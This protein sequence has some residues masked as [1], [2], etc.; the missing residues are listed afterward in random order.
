M[1]QNVD[2]IE[3]QHSEFDVFQAKLNEQLDQLKSI[4][5]RPGFGQDTLQLG[6]ELEMYLVDNT[7]E[8]SL[9]NQQLLSL[10]ND[11]QYQ[12]EL[13]QYNLE[14]N[15]SPVL[16]AGTPF[17]N[18]RQQMQ[19]KTARLEQVAQSININIVPIGILPTLR[20]AHMN[21]DYM[22]DIQRYHCLSKHLYQERGGHFEININGDESLLTSFSDICAEG[23]NTSFQVH[24]MIRPDKFTQVYNAA[25]LTLPFVTAIGANSGI[26]LGRK[27]WDE[28]RIA[29]FKQSI[30]IRHPNDKPWQEQ[31]RVNFGTG[32]LHG[33]PFQLFSQAVSLFPPVIPAL[34]D[35]P[36][37]KALPPLSELSLHLGTTWPWHRPVYSNN[38]NGHIRLE[39]RAIPA[40]PTSID[41]LANAAFAIGLAVGFSELIDDYISVLPFQYAEYNFYRAAQRGLNAKVLWPYKHKYHVGEVSIAAIIEGI[42][43]IAKQGLLSLDITEQ[44]TDK[45]LRVIENRL[46]DKI[47]GA[48]WQKRTFS[49]L[50]QSQTRELACKTLTQVYLQNCRTCRPVSEWAQLWR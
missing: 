45:Y 9:S 31:P 8:V 4:M 1:G 32:W 28:T 14:L 19:E 41:M 38:G 17:S 25:Q 35:E 43:P 15:L 11:S 48:T 6:A 5:Q 20:K 13:N 36:N 3:Y 30:D 22:T 39:F 29:L 33:S 18:L 49:F 21:I 47:N 46:V 24:L 34:D 37:N 2:K 12:P 23:A 42:L 50:E 7:G 27:L 44:E 40:G 10:L 26:F 16:L